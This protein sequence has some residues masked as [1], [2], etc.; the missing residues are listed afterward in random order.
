MSSNAAHDRLRDE[1]I[2]KVGGSPYARV[3][4]NETGLVRA[5]DNPQRIFFTGLIGSP[6]ILGVLC[7]GIFLGIEIKTGKGKLRQSQLNFRKMLLKFG[8]V[9]IEGRTVEQIYSE[10]E[11][12]ATCRKSSIT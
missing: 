12:A 8:G 7:T 4:S 9:F 1:A 3:W 2:L 5:F 10:V 11:A 6:D